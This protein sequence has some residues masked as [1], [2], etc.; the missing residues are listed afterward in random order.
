MTDETKAFEQWAV[1]ELMGHR[2]LAGLLSEQTIAGAAFLRI[3]IPS[4]TEIPTA[5]Q[6]YAPGA[7]YAITPCTEATARRIAEGITWTPPVSQWELPTPRIE[8]PSDGQTQVPLGTYAAHGDPYSD[9]V[10]LD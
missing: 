10:A 9:D 8:A 2:R 3:D 4:D 7:V 6:W 5:T 1:L